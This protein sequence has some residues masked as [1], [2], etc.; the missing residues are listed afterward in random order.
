MKVVIAGEIPFV[1]EV[2]QLCLAASWLPQPERV[3]GF[4]LVPPLPAGGMVELASGLQ[5][6]EASL[7]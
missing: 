7:T 2:G 6:A 1:E 3:V 5:T 4:G